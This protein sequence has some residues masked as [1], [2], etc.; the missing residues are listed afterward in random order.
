MIAG[1]TLFADNLLAQNDRSL[2]AKRGSKN[3]AITETQEEPVEIKDLAMIRFPKEIASVKE[4]FVGGSDKFVVHI[5]DAHCNYEAQMNIADVT[6]RMVEDYSVKLIGVEGSVGVIDTSPFANFP[7]KTIIKETADYFVTKGKL[8]GPEYLSITEK[9]PFTI[10]GI[11]T[12][13]YYNRN[14]NAFV[15]AIKFKDKAQGYCAKLIDPLEKIKFKIYSPEL[16]DIDDQYVSYQ[17]KKIDFMDYALNLEKWAKKYDIDT[18]V[19][20]NFTN[21][22]IVKKMEDK[23]SFEEIEKERTN[24]VNAILEASG[25][26]G[27]K[28]IIKHSIMFKAQKISPVDFYDFLIA[29]IDEN[30]LDRDDYPNLV[31]YQE[32]ITISHKIIPADLFTE[33][34]RL[35]EKVKESLYEND[36]QR[37]LS[38]RLKHIRILNNMFTLEVPK[39]EYLYYKNN[40]EEFRSDYF[41]SFIRKYAAGLGVL[42]EE[43]VGI[44]EIDTR[45]IIIEKF[46]EIALK[47]DDVLVNNLLNQM[48]EENVAVMICGGFHTTGI[49]ELLRK[50]DISYIVVAPKITQKNA[51]NPYVEVMLEQQEYM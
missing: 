5:Q 21:Q 23:F 44:I 43:P 47:R 3:T 28:S 33:V 17:E 13:K 48:K 49:T 6:R 35:T 2:F 20:Q 22:T 40:K 4:Q 51:T 46:Y 37:K 38:R 34:D 10:Y 19:Y 26:D 45:V 1:A 18:N 16:R 50:K 12:E 24:L 36:K 27:I 31:I 8:T 32:Y 29:S 14:Y 7:D 30:K 42:F 25:K 9:L 39:H 11:E 15:Q 41:V